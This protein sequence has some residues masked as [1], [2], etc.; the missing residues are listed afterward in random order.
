MRRILTIIIVLLISFQSKAQSSNDYHEGYYYDLSK[1]KVVGLVNFDPSSDYIRFKSNNKA[2]GE[3]IKITD[4]SAIGTSMGNGADSL[5]VLTEDNKENNRYF[6][7][8]ILATSTTRLYY[9]YNKPGIVVSG[10]GPTMTIGPA[11][12]H[13]NGTTIGWTYSN[14]SYYSGLNKFVMYQDGNT[15]YKLTK[16]NYIEI[17]SKAFAD[18]PDLVKSIQNKDYKF[19]QLDDIITEYK[20]RDTSGYIHN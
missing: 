16:R 5:I 9:K 6:A 11:N 10:G 15:T 3:K 17:L 14:S 13:A 12:T 7:N 18:A 20:Q 4:I 2:K 8:F 19:K 1:Q